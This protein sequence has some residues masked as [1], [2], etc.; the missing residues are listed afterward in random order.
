MFDADP[1]S[2][3][4]SYVS[5]G[6]FIHDVA[7]FDAPFFGISPREAL[8]MD[9]QQRLVLELAWETF[10]RAGIAPH[11]LAKQQV[12]VFLGSGDQDY[13]D[14]LPPSVLAGEVQDY[15]STGNAGSVISGRIAYAL[16][17]EGPAVTIDT[18][19]S[20]SL[21]A[22]HLAVQ[23]LRQRDCALALAGGVMV[24]SRPGPFVAF[25]RQRGL[26]ADGR[27]KPFSDS[28]DGT[29]W[30]EGAGTLLL[31]RLSD[32]RRNGHPVLA[33]VR[34]SAVNSDGASNGLTAPNG[35][36][37]QRVIR[38]A[39]A[40]AQLAASDVDAVE[41]HGTGTTLGD[42]IEAQALLATYGQDRDRPLW[43]GS[44]K[45]NIGHAQG[46][47]GVGGVI[48][49]V[50]ALRNGVLPKTLH[51][52]EPT[53][54]VD[55]TAGNVSLLTEEQ[56]WVAGEKP[57]RAGVSSFGVSG[58]N[59]H[60]IVE[61]APAVDVEEPTPSWPAEVPV[62]WPLSGHG[63]AALKAQAARLLSVVD[64][65]S[66]LD[67]GFS[68]ATSRSPLSHRAVVLDGKAGVAALAD[69]E[70]SSNVV[71]GTPVEG[72]T[73]FLF[74]GQGAQRAGMGAEL[75]AA[76]PVFAAAFDEVCAE[77][78][79]HL[80]RPLKTVV[81]DKPRLINQTGYTQPALFA[82]EVALFRLLSSWGLKPDFLLGHSVGELAAAHVAGVLSL[83]DAC[84]LVAARAKLMQALPTGGAM[85]ALQATEDEVAPHLTDGVSIAAING[86]DSVVL[87][88]T[89]GAVAAAVAEFERPQVVEAQGVARVP[90]AAD[91]ADA[92]RVRRGRP[93]ADLR[94]AR[95][96][97]GLQRLR[98]AGRGRG[99]DAGVL[100]LARPRGR[101]V[102][103]RPHRARRPG[104]LAV[105]R[106]RPGRRAVRP[107]PSE[108]RRGRRA[109]PAQ[110][111]S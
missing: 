102:P 59:A 13:Y 55:W 106:G 7:Q 109:G 75:A 53:T 8:A 49:M 32:A 78:D 77:L 39:L 93:H 60:V 23:A 66:P 111:P 67:L 91:G 30:A 70:P 64:G 20:S 27:C 88:G 101:P 110:G 81:F 84:T 52:T 73:A 45:S 92:G 33:V 58:T 19:C 76:F 25:S 38:Q 41:G 87:S 29:G 37:Q 85:V 80:D 79:Q 11:S 103:R 18:A 31:E 46:A 72:L 100:G 22:L 107:G 44:I 86:P 17:L 51:V 15:L 3:G 12:G 40:N 57:R 98:R 69:G 6:G 10:E 104:R 99:R 5:E 43:L 89:E 16:G 97:A 48:K 65:L 24:M 4:T 35:P 21:V 9:P 14:E 94:P 96:P 56:P 108:L 26:A 47:A 50:Q 54:E 82:I 71:T 74:S 28:A 105:R 42:P 83:A 95:D 36:S 34:G 63:T 2:P 1:D 68:L 61:E 90:L 62:P